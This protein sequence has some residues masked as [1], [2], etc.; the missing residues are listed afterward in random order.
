MADECFRARQVRLGIGRLG[1]SIGKPGLRL[2]TGGALGKDQRVSGLRG[3]VHAAS[4]VLGRR[5]R[6]EAHGP[7]RAQHLGHK[8]QDGGP[9]DHHGG[10]QMGGGLD[11]GRSGLPASAT[12]RGEKLLAVCAVRG[13]AASIR[14]RAAKG[15]DRR[16]AD[17]RQAS[18]NRPNSFHRARSFALSIVPSGGNASRMR[19][20][21]ATDMSADEAEP[22]VHPP[23]ARLEAFFATRRQHLHARRPRRYTPSGVPGLAHS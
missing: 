10:R 15:V 12:D 19:L 9:L 14:G 23:S 22:K 20:V 5:G 16:G 4:V 21:A 17:G 6:R 18:S 8:C 11:C 1:T 2:N 13:A 7:A 3:Q